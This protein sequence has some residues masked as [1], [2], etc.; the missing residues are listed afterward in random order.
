MQ[1]ISIALLIIVACASL[2]A[3]DGDKDEKQSKCEEYRKH[4]LWVPY[5][6]NGCG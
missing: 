4:K 1:K 2:T 3:C 6:E 5:V